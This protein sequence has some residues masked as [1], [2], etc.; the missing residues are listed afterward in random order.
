MKDKVW[1]PCGGH[2]PPIHIEG[3]RLKWKKA[4]K[5]AKKNIISEVI[6]KSIPNNILCCTL[7]V[8]WP[9]KVASV[10]ISEN[11]R[12][13]LKDKIKILKTKLNAPLLK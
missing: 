1:I 13:K 9:S 5:N 7:K 6:N 11:Q 2:I 4:Q 10:I 3:E 12:N 8:W